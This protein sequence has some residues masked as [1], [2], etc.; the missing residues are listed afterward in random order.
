MNHCQYNLSTIEH[1][2]LKDADKKD[3][4]D[5]TQKIYRL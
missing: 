2:V 5:G 4:E 3:L 1:F